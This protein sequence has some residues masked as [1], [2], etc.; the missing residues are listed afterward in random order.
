MEQT[1]SPFSRA[2]QSSTFT[3][4]KA[5]AA[6]HSRNVV[7]NQRGNRNCALGPNA[8]GCLAMVCVG[9]SRAQGPKRTI[10]PDG[11]G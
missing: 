1:Y 5:N 6:Q 8:G 9:N 3:D 10:R 2:P 11:V 4:Y 7:H